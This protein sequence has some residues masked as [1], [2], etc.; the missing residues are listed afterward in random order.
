MKIIYGIFQGRLIKPPNGQLQYFPQNEWEKEFQLAQ[1]SGLHYIELFSEEIH[2]PNNPI[3]KNDG[4]KEI[5]KILSKNNLDSYSVSLNYL[6]QNPIIN[7]GSICE[8]NFNYVKEFLI[9]ISEIKPKIIVL[10]LLEKSSLNL[11]NFEL[12]SDFLKLIATEA[13]KFKMKIAIETI[14]SPVIQSKL[15]ERIGLNNVG[16][17]YDTGNRALIDN[18]YIND[19]NILKNKIIHVHLKDIRKPY[20]NVPVGTGIVDFKNILKK[21]DDFRYS[22]RFTFETHRGPDPFKTL[23]HNIEFINYVHSLI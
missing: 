23:L 7:E 2:N 19:L 17:V 3:W 22:G 21:L 18:D 4:R 16:L 14:S 12:M 20:G 10:P 9:K 15:I 1:S 5:S 11:E 6:I 8:K 13:Y